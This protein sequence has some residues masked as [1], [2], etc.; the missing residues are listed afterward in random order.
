MEEERRKRVKKLAL[1]FDTGWEYMPGS[2]EAGSVLTD[3]FWDMAESNKKRFERIWEK[4]ELAFLQVVPES[5]EKPDGVCGKVLIHASG[6]Q[7]G[8]W[9][10]E[11]TAVYMS[12]G[13]GESI[14]F[15]TVR[16][17]QL[18]S[19]LLRYA[20]YRRGPWAWLAYGEGDREELAL[21]QPVGKELAHPAFRWRFRGLCDG[22]SHF[23][24][25]VELG[26]ECL[27]AKPLSGAW[28]VSDGKRVF[29]AEWHPSDSGFMLTGQAPEFASNLE[30][31]LYEVRLALSP[32]REAPAEWL[33]A[34]SGAFSLTQESEES[35]PEL[36]LTPLGAGD[37][38]RVLP[39][40][41][42]PEE[43]ASLYLACDRLLAAGAGRQI[44]LRYKESYLEEEKRPEPLPEAYWKIYRK[45][46]KQLPLVREEP[47]SEWRTTDTVW[48]YFNGRMWRLLPDSEGW[49]TG[50]GEPGEKV[51]EW[52][53]PKDMR[54]CAVEGEEHLYIR[55]RAVRVEN[56]YAAYY[57]KR[58][59]LL[60]A[61]RLE[62]GERRHVC[63]GRR[64][65]ESLREGEERM[66]LGFDRE[67]TPDNCWYTGEEACTLAGGQFMGKRV[68]YGKEAF[69]VE[70]TE[71]KEASLSCFRPNYVPVCKSF[72]GEGEDDTGFCIEA[73]AT[74][75]VEPQD[76]GLL[77]AL[78]L[79]DIRC[80]RAEVS[81]RRY[82]THFGRLL[83]PM[84][85]EVMLQERYPSLEVDS[86]VFR[87]ENRTLEVRLSLLP[88]RL[89]SKAYGSE[90]EARQ[91]LLDRLPELE[92]W[93]R[94]L[95]NRKGPFWL[96]GTIV[97]I[98]I[99]S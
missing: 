15:H 64:L 2:E 94:E 92:E 27:P 50:S 20:V 70:M 67:V 91:E 86:C 63:V 12:G 16:P 6:E 31:G 29:D 57:H 10:P 21:F 69:W 44:T 90:R 82:F 7:D 71:R 18:S 49:R 37:G 89:D 77:D 19:A 54:P 51:C 23:C 36:C 95:L 46:C 13:A 53:C 4:H 84:D 52:S 96:I 30:G 97:K 59:P 75:C 65:P 32:E 22:R 56:A 80:G 58:I 26:G 87:R 81:G 35:G 66:Y 38:G 25:R 78:C 85:M 62:A 47:L 48:E 73:G 60:E 76:M 68:L 55:L 99:T 9:L 11:G 17:V 34:L 42:S 1:A 28:T 5:R 43:G 41:V 61:V 8:R 24:L 3:I 45:G 88:N 79:S 40:G 74:C 14:R 33:E 72:T 39:F 93:L 98:N 83:T